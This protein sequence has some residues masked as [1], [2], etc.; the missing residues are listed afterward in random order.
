[1][2]LRLL[3]EDIFFL[4][5]YLWC[6]WNSH[7]SPGVTGMQGQQKEGT[8]ARPWR[9]VVRAALFLGCLRRPPRGRKV[10]LEACPSTTKDP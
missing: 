1:M 4:N 10:T 8:L 2:F 5:S 6:L 9:A 3:T 7:Q